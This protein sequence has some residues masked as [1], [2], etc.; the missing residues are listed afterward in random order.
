MN[1]AGGILYLGAHVMLSLVNDHLSNK[2]MK[3]SIK[4]FTWLQSIWKKKVIVL[5]SKVKVIVNWFLKKSD[6]DLNSLLPYQF[7]SNLYKM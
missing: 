6:S 2:W 4:P 5:M 1:W 7:D 3:K